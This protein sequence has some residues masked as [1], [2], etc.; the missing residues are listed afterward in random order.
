MISGKKSSLR[1]SWSLSFLRMSP[2]LTYERRMAR[3]GRKGKGK[4]KGKGK[5]K[6]DS[7]GDSAHA[8]GDASGTGQTDQTQTSKETTKTQ[9]TTAISSHDP[10]Y[11]QLSWSDDWLV[12]I[13]MG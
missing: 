2:S 1:R 12:V 11:E 10:T 5:G 4:D 6:S 7:F 13:P 3:K 8:A 9:E